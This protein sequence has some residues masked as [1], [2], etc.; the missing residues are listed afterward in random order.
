[1]TDMRELRRVLD[2]QAQLAPDGVGMIEAARAGA[3]RLR[4]R[5][6]VGYVACAVAA[7]ALL[8]GVSTAIVGIGGASTEQGPSAARQPLQL[9]LDLAPDSDYH[10]QG[11]G[12]VGG[13][14][15]LVARALNGDA[16][17]FGAAVALYEPGT[18]DSAGLVRGEKIT[19]GGHPAYFVSDFLAGKG[20][21]PPGPGAGPGPENVDVRMP[22][23]GWREPS[24]GWVVVYDVKDKAGLARIAEDVRVGAARP[25]KTP[26]RL[27]YVPA[28][29]PATAAVTFDSNPAESN[30]VV[31]FDATAT[32]TL[33]DLRSAGIPGVPA[34]KIQVVPRSE[35]VDSHAGNL[36]PPTKIGGWDTWYITTQDKGW[37]VPQRGSV[38]VVNAGHCQAH[39]VVRDRSQI[40]YTELNRLVADMTFA[41]CTD[42]A[43]WTRP[44]S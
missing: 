37:V 6:K 31:G 18:F 25:V 10:K 29:L 39:I 21:R 8:A 26:Y 33:L 9:T 22:V 2:A 12:V 5:R 28:D 41:D 42:P 44:L 17:E 1:M 34:L 11:Y 15:F 13:T 19:V 27:G 24:G 7:A 16:R 14:Q 4:N 35:Y 36:G 40:P 20:F 32:P 43:T 23:I 3:V 38:L 30:S